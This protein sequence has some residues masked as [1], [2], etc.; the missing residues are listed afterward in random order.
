MKDRADLSE[1][2]SL[3][4]GGSVRM[5][6]EPLWRTWQE[7]KRLREQNTTASRMK[8][9]KYI[10]IGILIAAAVLWPRSMDLSLLLQFTVML[11]S[12]FIAMQAA[13]ESR[14]VF[15]AVFA[16]MAL[17]YNPVFPASDLLGEWTRVLVVGSVAPFVIS[18]TWRRFRLSP[19]AI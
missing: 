4:E 5:L 9:I 13:Q 11:S 10:S 3:Y 1:T 14:Y 2:Q 19:L 12:V 6:E 7:K 18:L 17:L 8:T 15:V 16:S